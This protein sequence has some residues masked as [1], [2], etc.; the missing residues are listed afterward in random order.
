[1]SNVIFL[2]SKTQIGLAGDFET[3]V[4]NYFDGNLVKNARGGHAVDPELR[5]LHKD[6]LPQV[7]EVV[8]YLNGLFKRKPPCGGGNP[9]EG[10]IRRGSENIL[11]K[12]NSDGSD[13]QLTRERSQTLYI[14]P[15]TG[16]GGWPSQ[17]SHSP[18]GSG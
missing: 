17:Y 7:N 14:T 12:N 1:L 10:R 3:M 4:T 13:L 5:E 9:D 8:P 11:D 15:N 16:S 18:G 2:A 6:L